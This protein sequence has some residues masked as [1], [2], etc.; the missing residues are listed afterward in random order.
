MK[1]K[2]HGVI[3]FMENH[4][5]ECRL[6]AGCGRCDEAR[7][8]VAALKEVLKDVDAEVERRIAERR[9]H[10]NPCVSNAKCTVCDH[11][12]DDPIYNQGGELMGYFCSKCGEQ[13]DC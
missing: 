12:F 13:T 7:Q 10:K 11:E 6:N 5:I 8:H 3:T 9:E 4:V 2:I 1:E